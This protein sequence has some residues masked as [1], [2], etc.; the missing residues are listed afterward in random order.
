MP[1]EN[2]I[3]KSRILPPSQD[4]DFLL[5]EGLK[6]VE[7]LGNKF[8]TD[9]NPHDPGI[10][11]LEV[12]CYAITELGYRADFNIKDVLTVKNGKI[13]NNTFFTASSIFSNAALTETDYRK[14]LIDIDGISNAWFQSNKRVTDENGYFLPNDS[15]AKIYIN[16]LEDK[17]SLKNKDRN[18]QILP[19]LHL[20][21]LNK[22]KIELDED[23]ELGDLNTLLL[24]YAFWFEDS[25]DEKK[26]RWV[27]LKIVPQFT[28]WNHPDAGLFKKMDK[29]SK[30]TIE[31]IKKTQ[32]KNVLLL[33]VNRYAKPSDSLHFRIFCEDVSEIDIALD[34]FSKEKAVCD[35]I[36][37][38]LKKKEKIQLIFT[39]LDTILHQNRNLTE[40]FLCK[41]IVEKVDIGICADIEIEPG[42]DS[43]EIMAQIQI[44]IDKIIR[45][46][47]HF[48]TLNQLVNEGY[49]SEDIFAGPKLTHGFLK[50]SEIEKSQLPKEI[51]ASDI[52]AVLMEIKGVKS[53]KN[54]MMTAYN[55]LGQ[56][57]ANAMN[58]SWVLELS[59]EVKPIFNQ[60]ISKLLLFQKNIPFLHS[61]TQTMLVDQKVSMYKMQFSQKKLQN[62]RMDFEITGGEYFELGSYYSIQE[63]FPANYLLGKNRVSDKES[64]LRKAQT[65]QLK[66]YLYFF[67]QILADFFSQLYNAKDLLN[68]KIDNDKRT[69]FPVFIDKNT[70]TGE[71]FYSKE[72]YSG[73]LKSK[74]TNGESGDDISL[75]E[76]KEQYYDRKN[77][78]LDHLLARFAESFND[79]VFM[80]YQVSHD[81]SGMGALTFDNDDLILDKQNFINSYPEISSKRGLGID[82]LNSEI[83]ENVFKFKPFWNT[84]YRGGYEKRT[85]KLL[86]INE[87]PLR[88]IVTEDSPQTQWTVETDK[89]NF[90]FKIIAPETDLIEKWNWSQ[91]HFLDQ[92]LYRINKFGS[93]YYLYLVNGTKKIARF[94]KKFVSENEA[95]V[96]LQK[97]MK[98]LNIYYE[99]FYC[100]EHILLRPYYNTSSD[101]DL[102]TVCLNDN[103]DD[104]ANNDP[105][106]F[107]ATIV[108]PGYISRFKNLTFRLYAEQIFRQEAPAH[109][110]LKICWVGIDDMLQFQKAYRNWIENYR[111]FRIKYCDNTLSD[112]G[113]KE[114]KQ[115]LSELVQKIKELN[116]IYPEGNLYD[117]QISETTNPIILGS[118]SLG[119]I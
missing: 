39:T 114:Y 82:Y 45:P 100:I 108:L 63:D 40:D 14:L 83:V 91:Q 10:T 96:Y 55:E 87:I 28:N 52:I 34:Y 76:S 26:N 65:K 118:T 73:L 12:L 16:K 11:I 22:V 41:E 59:G 62:S 37:L 7:K 79:Y 115:S 70:E 29:P 8:W 53:V 64:T 56:P 102:L 116:T 98:I 33:I 72:I 97:M 23:P 17:L 1:A 110:L 15:E 109:V 81:T 95:Y 57:M 66:G 61:E 3:D 32:D 30:I 101:D 60:K 68:T 80:M 103:C 75:Y 93:N 84:D 9:Y 35:V 89:G 36:S 6:Y 18:N 94:E 46:K 21:G 51:Y 24:E 85:A 105:Y 27:N 4:Y 38:F 119:T 13:E 99:N 67:E 43:I 112:A 111:T 50:D 71:D 78:A 107:K 49:H 47:I 31:S 2:I 5:Q 44:A 106:S 54:L 117:C 113:K 92:N 48:Y 88:N 77:R 74:L 90:L 19:E 25:K 69:Y 42:A 104:E 20:R 86:G 58:K